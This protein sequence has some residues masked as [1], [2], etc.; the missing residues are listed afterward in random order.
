MAMS[1]RLLR[2][3]ASGVH[4]EANAW[5]SAVVANGGSVSASTMN[6][7][8]RFCAAIDAA[9]I[10]SKFRRLNLF[11]GNSDA[12]LIAVRVPL[13]RG[14]SRTGTQ[15]GNTIDTNVN[16]VQGDYAETGANGGLL[17]DSSSKLLNTGFATQDLP[18]V[19]DCHIAVWWRGGTATEAR[20]AIGALGASSDLYIIDARTTAGGGTQARLGG[21]T[22]FT[23][24]GG[25][26]D[27]DPQSMIASRT[28]SNDAVFY[29][30][31]VSGGTQ[32]TNVTG[33]TGTSQVFGVFA[34]LTSGTTVNGVFPFRLNGYSIG[35]GL[36]SG[37]ATSFHNAWAAFQ[38]ALTRGL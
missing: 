27:T 4:P 26:I 2:P 13:Y 28:A 10:R 19:S 25:V 16:F 23:G 11:C 31:G 29:K 3:L 8:S 14:E 18:G 30:N 33:V 22:N 7:V 1:P 9:A 24:S 37:E 17:G 34:G 35:A 20:R 36:T 32:T 5:R 38:T 15:Y 6:A 12:S 21:S